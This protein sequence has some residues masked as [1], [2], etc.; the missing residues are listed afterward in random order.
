LR[1][2]AHFTRRF[3]PDAEIERTVSA[4]SSSE[5]SEMSSE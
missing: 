5:A 4:A 1:A 2:L 3:C